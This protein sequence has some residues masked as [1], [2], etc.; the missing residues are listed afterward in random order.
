MSTCYRFITKNT[1][2]LG[3]LK[4]SQGEE[5]RVDIGT[6]SCGSLPV[7]MGL[8]LGKGPAREGKVCG[9]TM[10]E[11]IPGVLGNIY[12][13]AFCHEPIVEGGLVDR[14]YEVGW[15]VGDTVGEEGE[16]LKAGE[17]RHTYV[18]APSWSVLEVGR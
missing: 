2:K 4:S 15:R 10:F 16:V 12:L 13:G 1:E 9:T 17:R 14:E 8:N 18:P 6:G 7:A 5:W 11:G 3:E